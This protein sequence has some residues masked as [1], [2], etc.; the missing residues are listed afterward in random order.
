MK[1]IK[2]KKRKKIENNQSKIHHSEKKNQSGTISR[3][4]QSTEDRYSTSKYSQENAVILQGTEKK[5][6]SVILL[7]SIWPRASSSRQIILL[8]SIRPR[9]PL[10]GR[11]AVII[12]VRRSNYQS[13][14]SIRTNA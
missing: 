7:M 13:L 11:L 3:Y 5:A 1:K 4:S 8:I 2:K 10:S 12:G 14:S 9:T 6:E